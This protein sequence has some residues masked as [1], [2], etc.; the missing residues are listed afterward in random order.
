MLKP[1]IDRLSAASLI[2]KKLDE[3]LPKTLG[4]RNRIRIF[5]ATDLEGYF[6]AVYVVAQKTRVLIKDVEKFEIIHKKLEM[7][8]DHAIKR[9]VIMLDAPLCS[10]AEASFKEHGWTILR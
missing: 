8:Q 5:A 6:A 2:Y 7:Y 10:K 4:I 9:K 1:I 3:V